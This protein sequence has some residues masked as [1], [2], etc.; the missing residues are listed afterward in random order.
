MIVLVIFLSMEIPSV[1]GMATAYEILALILAYSAP[2]FVSYDV[3]V[4]ISEIVEL[5]MLLVKIS[6]M[7]ASVGLCTKR[8]WRT[9]S[10][11]VFLVI[12]MS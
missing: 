5:W 11:S 12:E 3:D 10:S 1:K 9:L 6:S 2:N 8:I 4:V 7:S